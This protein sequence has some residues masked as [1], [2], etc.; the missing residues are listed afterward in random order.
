ML[1]DIFIERDLNICDNQG[2]NDD[3]SKRCHFK[4]L[5]KLSLERDL[6]PRLC[7]TSAEL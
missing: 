3:V 6:D 4:N 7:D 1:I 2:R 5:K